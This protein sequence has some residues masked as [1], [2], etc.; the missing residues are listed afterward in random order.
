MP[1]TFTTHTDSPLELITAAHMNLVQTAASTL[2]SGWITCEDTWVYASSTSFTISGKDCTSY[3]TKGTKLKCTNSGT[4]YFYI[5]SSSFSTNTTV[6]V[7]GGSDYTVANAAITAPSYSY[8]EN[9]QGFPDWFNYTPTITG[10]SSN[11][12]TTAYRFAIKGT[13]VFVTLCE[14]A[15]GTSNATTKTYTLPITS[16]TITNGQHAGII[17]AYTDN[18]SAGYNGIWVVPSA[19]TTVNC[20]KA[21]LA[22]WTNSGNCVVWGLNATTLGSTVI[23]EM[24]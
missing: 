23:Y 21:S 13:T 4:K 1:T 14:G 11:P 16:K 15:N 17:V 19:S 6:N 5:T 7:T 2:E 24:A 3:M 10:F 20:Y 18:G 8:E 9:P 12:T 22:A